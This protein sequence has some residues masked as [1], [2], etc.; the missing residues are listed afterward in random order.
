MSGYLID[1]GIISRVRVSGLSA[2]EWIGSA[3]I[4]VSI[5]AVREVMAN[6]PDDDIKAIGNLAVL[7]A[8]PNP[9]EASDEIGALAQDLVA[10]Y[11]RHDPPMAINDAVIAATALL[12]KKVLIT[13]N[14]HDFHYVEGLEWIDANGLTTESAPLLGTRGPVTGSI[15]DRACCGRLRRSE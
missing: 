6:L 7:T 11:A 4:S 10:A 5:V 8:L 9:I 3:D 15:A 1:T 2:A 13:L 14:T 12:E